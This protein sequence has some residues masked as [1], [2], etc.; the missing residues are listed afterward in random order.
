MVD[1]QSADFNAVAC[2][3]DRLPEGAS[4]EDIDREREILERARGIND[5][6]LSAVVIANHE[7]FVQEVS[8]HVV[9]DVRPGCCSILPPCLAFLSWPGLWSFSATCSMPASCAAASARSCQ[10]HPRKSAKADSRFV[11][12]LDGR[13]WTACDELTNRRG[14][15]Q[16]LHNYRK[17]QKL[18]L[19]ERI[20]ST[21]FELNQAK[22]V[23]VGRLVIVTWIGRSP[24]VQ[25]IKDAISRE[26]FPLAIRRCSEAMRLVSL[27]QQFDCVKDMRFNEVLESIEVRSRRPRPFA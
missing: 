22:S 8:E 9:P 15:Y 16:I 23:R 25:V 12:V 13:R 18:I 17:R 6:K 3:L 27:S 7:S 11:L 5:T 20:C 24:A 10:M 14:G 21:I 1:G 2:V 19:L 4:L 26:N